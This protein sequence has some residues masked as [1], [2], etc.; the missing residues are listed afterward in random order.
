MSQTSDLGIVQQRQTSRHTGTGQVVRGGYTVPVAINLSTTHTYTQKGCRVQRKEKETRPQNS[1]WSRNRPNIAAG[2]SN[3]KLFGCLPRASAK[4]LQKA[5]RGNW[6]DN[7]KLG[8]TC[9]C[10]ALLAATARQM[11]KGWLVVVAV[12]THCIGSPNHHEVSCMPHAYLTNPKHHTEK[13][14]VSA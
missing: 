3:A 11:P 2:K 10:D 14:N 6:S 9:I 13:E 12:R 5:D 7:G 4:L 8:Q 1:N